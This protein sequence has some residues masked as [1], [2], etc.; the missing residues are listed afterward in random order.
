M[1]S[2]KYSLL[3]VA[4][5]IGMTS[6]ASA[7]PVPPFEFGPTGGTGPGNDISK[8]GTGGIQ[9]NAN[10]DASNFFRL[11]TVV[12]GYN[13]ANPL[14]PL[15]TPI[16]TGAFDEPGN[17]GGIFNVTGFEYAVL[18]YG[19]GNGGVKG[20]GGG[21]EFFFL[22]GL[23]SFN[24]PLNGTGL[25]G[26]GGISSVTLFKGAAPTPDGGTTVMLLGTALTGLGVVRRY[27]KR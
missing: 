1:K 20:S 24:V 27:L 25:N 17:T 21:V 7:T 23:T 5:C 11:Q 18:H 8:N 13:T 16:S 6:L 10:N 14:T 19:V 26:F 12:T 2:L 22:D 4:L 3:L 9:P 15:P